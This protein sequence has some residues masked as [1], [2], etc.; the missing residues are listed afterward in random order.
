M[1]PDRSAETDL[2]LDYVADLGH[3]WT[4]AAVLAGFEAAWTFFGGIFAVIIPD[5]A[6]RRIIDVLFP[7][8]LCGRGRGG[9]VIT[10]VNGSMPLVVGT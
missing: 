2:W 6:P 7:S 8:A 1:V 9:H 5:Y 4:T 3:G 10:A